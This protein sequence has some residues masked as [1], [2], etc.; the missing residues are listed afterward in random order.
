MT[1]N[2]IYRRCGC[3]TTDGK[4]Y[5]VLPDRATAKQKAN[6]C[7]LMEDPNHGKWGYYIS[8]GVDPKTG[9]RRQLRVA[10]FTTLKAAQTARNKAAVKVDS[11]TYQATSKEVYADYLERWLPRHQTHGEGLKATTYMNYHRY[12]SMDIGPSELGR[13][14]LAD[15]RR[16]HINAFIDELL[17]AGRGATTVRRIAAVVQGSLRSAE[18]ED[19]IEQNPSVGIRLPK[20]EKKDFHAWEPEQVGTFLDVA[21][22]HRLG[23]LF[24][25]AMLTG[26]RRGELIGMRWSDVDL[27]RRQLSIRNNR[28]QAGNRIVENA[29]KTKSGRRVLD[30]D[31]RTIGALLGWKASQEAQE[32]LWGDA[33]QATGYVFTYENGE[34]LRPQ[35][36]SRLFD[37]LRV[38]ADLPKITF[39]GQRHE[40]ASLMI[41]SGADIAIVAK[42]LGHSSVSITADLYAHLIG[43]ASRLAGENAAALLPP[44]TASAHTLHTQGLKSGEEAK[45]KSPAPQ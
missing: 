40:N 43:S 29:P 37:K 11:N 26:M 45:M 18:Q 42:R 2:S 35:Y 31:D 17:A 38:K 22:Q 25:L 5:P 12:A 13:M 30:L 10:T 27:A 36:V 15:I 4:Q 1:M 39:H 19:L 7:P 28:V 3:R 8:A 41:A 32:A 20:V 24:E 21:A 6:A 34:P 9:R 14:K 23:A 16:F 33:W 44:K